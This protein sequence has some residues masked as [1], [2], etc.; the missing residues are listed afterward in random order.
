[1]RAAKAVSL[2]RANARSATPLY[3][4]L[5]ASV[6]YCLIPRLRHGFPKF[7]S[8]HSPPLS[9]LTA[10]TAD[11]VP[12][13]R[14]SA[15]NDPNALAA[16]NFLPWKYTRVNRVQS[17]RRMSVYHF[18]PILGTVIVSLR[19]TVTG[20][21]VLSALRCANLVTGFRSPFAIDQPRHS[22][23]SPLRLTPCC[24]TVS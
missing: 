14:T 18:P 20:C 19:S 1:M 5:S 7:P 17:S 21:N 4:G 6:N 16:S 24:S 2:I 13:A 10:I 3:S 11:G 22:W 23:S 9:D 12:S 8:K 15:R